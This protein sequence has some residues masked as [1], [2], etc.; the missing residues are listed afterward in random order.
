[1]KRILCRVGGAQGV[2]LESLVGYHYEAIILVVPKDKED[3]T[4]PMTLT[5]AVLLDSGSEAMMCVSK[6]LDARSDGFPASKKRQ[7][8]FPFRRD[9]R[10]RVARGRDLLRKLRTIEGYVI[11]CKDTA[12]ARGDRSGT[13]RLFAGRRQCAAFRVKECAG[14]FRH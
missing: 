10:A 3:Q 6:K 13:S 4:T 2:D 1:M 5:A 7:L 8:A 12:D 14:Q 9:A 11:Y